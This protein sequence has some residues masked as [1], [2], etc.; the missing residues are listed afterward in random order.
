MKDLLGHELEPYSMEVE[1]GKIKELAIAIVDDNPIFYSLESAKD[2]DYDG[3]PVPL[4][5]FANHWRLWLSREN[6]GLLAKW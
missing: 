6:G 3:I 1:K 5:F 4:T 2:A